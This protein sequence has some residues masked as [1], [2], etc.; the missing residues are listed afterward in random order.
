MVAAAAPPAPPDAEPAP[1]SAAPAV[2][3]DEL[4]PPPPPPAAAPPDAEQA[5]ASLAAHRPELEACLSEAQRAPGGEALAGRRPSL[6]LEIAPAGSTSARLGDA[7]ADLDP[8]P[9]G[10]CLRRVAAGLTFPPFEGSSVRLEVPL[11]PGER[12]EP[13]P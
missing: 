3:K 8:T 11:P 1:P 6:R 2:A 5:A 4:P 9:L 13:P 7:D 10:A 12:A